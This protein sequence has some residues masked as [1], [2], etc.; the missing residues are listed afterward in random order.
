[1]NG[2]QTKE[3]AS[4]SRPSRWVFV[5]AAIYFL[6]HILTAA[7][8]GHFRSYES[9]SV[10]AKIENPY[11]LYYET[12]PMLLSHGRKENYQMHWDSVKKWE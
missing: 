4:E 7:R 11:A 10:A 3:S 5:V 2:T 12:R 6:L 9:V 1:M 8:Y